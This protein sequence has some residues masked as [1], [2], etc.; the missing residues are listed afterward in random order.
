MLIATPF[1]DYTANMC[2]SVWHIYNLSFKKKKKIILYLIVLWR[3]RVW[4]IKLWHQT[5]S[6]SECV[7]DL[8]WR[9]VCQRADELRTGSQ[10]LHF[11]CKP[12]DILKWLPV[13]CSSLRKRIRQKKKA[14]FSGSVTVKPWGRVE[15][16]AEHKLTSK[17]P[18]HH[19]FSGCWCLS[20]TPIQGCGRQSNLI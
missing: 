11:Q 9:T 8:A 4:G 2:Q 3:P 12:A 14:T 16:R 1:R 18:K 6:P 5:Q 7:S 13:G 19:S 17:G 20:W 15:R 10:E